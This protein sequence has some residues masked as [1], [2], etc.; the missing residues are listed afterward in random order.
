VRH[1]R[2]IAVREGT[3]IEIYPT[4]AKL[5][6]RIWTRHVDVARSSAVFDVSQRARDG[7]PIA[8]ERIRA[9]VAG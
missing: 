6:V 9:F 2:S 7:T 5:P 8:R 4:A 1:A 3:R